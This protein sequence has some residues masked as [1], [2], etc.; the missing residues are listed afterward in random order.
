[1]ILQDKPFFF[2]KIEGCCSLIESLLFQ[3]M[4]TSHGSKKQ[5]LKVEILN[6]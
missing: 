1:M 5:N 6:I 4:L 2:F 3:L